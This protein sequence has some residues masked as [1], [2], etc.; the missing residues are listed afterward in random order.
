MA[1]SKSL[2]LSVL[3]EAGVT[4]PA[5]SQRLRAAEFGEHDASERIGSNL[6]RGGDSSPQIASGSQDRTIQ[7]KNP[8]ENASFHGVSGMGDIGLDSSNNPQGIREVPPELALKLA[9]FDVASLWKSI[10]ADDRVATLLF[11]ESRLKL[12]S[13]GRTPGSIPE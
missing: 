1:L 4:L 8:R 12:R 10:E 5:L 9:L 7:R 3:S 13:Q 6:G 11:L 2:R